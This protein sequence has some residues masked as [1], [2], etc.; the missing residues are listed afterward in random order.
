MVAW[1]AGG[2]ATSCLPWSHFAPQKGKRRAE[3][4]ALP[5]WRDPGL[6]LC[7]CPAPCGFVLPLCPSPR[8]RALQASAPHHGLEIQQ[9]LTLLLLFLQL[10]G[11]EGALAAH[12]AGVRR[13]HV[14][15]A[16]GRGN[17]APQMGRGAPVPAG[18][19]WAQLPHKREEAAWGSDSSLPLPSRAT[20]HQKDQTELESP[21]CRRSSSCR[22]S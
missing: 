2:T 16:A 4:A 15:G 10:L 18:S 19:S 6:A 21:G 5:E 17:T 20:G 11:A 8:G 9:S 7:L 1:R 22:R 12:T 3:A 13:G 14:P